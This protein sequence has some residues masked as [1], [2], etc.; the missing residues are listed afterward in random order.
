[1]PRLKWITFLQLLIIFNAF[2]SVELKSIFP[3]AQQGIYSALSGAGL[4]GS[5]AMEN[6]AEAIN[7]MS[8]IPKGVGQS[9]KDLFGSKKQTPCAKVDIL[10]QINIFGLGQTHYA[11]QPL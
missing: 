9:I 8:N 2:W 11:E 5:L 4:T 3:S 1:M 6:L 7:N 10:C